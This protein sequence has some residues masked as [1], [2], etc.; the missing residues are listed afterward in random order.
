MRE[1]CAQ[2]SDCH[3]VSIWTNNVAIVSTDWR[4][5]IIT[6][7]VNELML[8]T[9]LRDWHA[10][11]GARLVDFA[12]WEMP[13]QYTSIVE[14]H[15]AVRQRVGLFDI[16]HMGR[17][18]FAGPQACDF[19]DHILTNHVARME[20]GQVRY[21]LVC[22]EDGG[23]LDDVL[24]YR[25][26]Q[27]YLLVVN[28][29]NREKIVNWISQQSGDYDFTI[30]DVTLSTQMIAIQGPLAE[31]V[32]APHVD[33]NLDDLKYYTVVEANCLGVPAV[34]SR[35]GYTGEDGFEV[36]VS[37][38]QGVMVWT[39]LLKAGGDQI[40]PCGLGC[41]DTLRLE[42]AMPLYGHEMDETV[43]PITA[44]LRFGVKADKEEFIGKPA[45]DAV[46]QSGAKLKRIGIELEGRRI[47]REGA[48]LIHNDQEVGHVT[49]GTFSPTLQK[50]IAMGYVQTDLAIPGNEI[51]VDIRG[52]R[53]PARIVKLPFYKR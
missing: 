11:N 13:I 46:L 22:Q 5:T 25:F 1:T 29:A 14:E 20:V 35:T 50:S 42:A 15:H 6:E 30:D 39:E 10:D 28:G 31:Q 48:K 33:T 26:E 7:K 27:K 19:L 32:L 9:V 3:D 49:S 52:K 21:A 8:Q 38:D 24:V 2:N 23:I 37:K 43:D 12:G 45:I 47:A 41:R 17:I 44:G 51:V 4:S 16:A 36:S 53:E 34:I 18:W 40:A